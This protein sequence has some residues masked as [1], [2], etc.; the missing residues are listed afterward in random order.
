MDEIARKKFEKQKEHRKEILEG[1]EELAR[2]TAEKKKAER[3]A[4]R[5][6]K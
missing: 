4:L 2:K 1:K 3:E 6:L 5:D